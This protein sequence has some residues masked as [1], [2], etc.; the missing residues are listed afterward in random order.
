MH[1]FHYYAQSTEAFILQQ[2]TSNI[3]WLVNAKLTKFHQYTC[4][5]L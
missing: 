5:I 1:L 3:S 2:K 4:S